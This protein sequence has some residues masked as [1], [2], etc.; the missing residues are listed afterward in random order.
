[1]C[2]ATYIQQNG[3]LPSDNHL[4]KET[5]VLGISC[6]RC[7]GPGADHVQNHSVNSSNPANAPR[8][9]TMPPLT[10]SR[11]RQIHICAQCHSGA[12]E[13]LAPAFSFKPGDAISD[14]VKFPEPNATDRL[15]VHGNQVTLLKRSRC[16]Q[17]SPGMSCATCHDPHAPERPAAEY[18]VRCLDCHQAQQCGEVRKVGKQLASNCIDCHMPVQSSNLLVLDADDTRLKAKVRNHWIRVYPRNAPRP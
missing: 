11:D 14:Y 8:K 15:D 18:S 12:G 10:L 9:N 6:E 13:P 3:S 4:N 16:F 7:H 5:I 2:H 17:S 1:E